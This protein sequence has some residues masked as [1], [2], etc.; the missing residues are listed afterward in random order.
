MRRYGI[1]AIL[2]L[3]LLVV[4]AAGGLYVAKSKG[5]AGGVVK[6]NDKNVSDYSAVFLTN[7]Q[8]Y[9]GKIEG[10]SD[11]EVTIND[12]YYLQVANQQVQPDTSKSD[13]TKQPDISL[14]KLGNELHGP[15]DRM[16][17][18]RDQVLFTESL[19]SDSKV[20]SAIKDYKN[21]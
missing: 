7:G 4:L 21:K 5:L 6:D 19:K 1:T 3:L 20:V 13:D 16:H 15:N 2:A 10:I 9:F 14:V 18:N 12:I 17:I 11:R 8:V